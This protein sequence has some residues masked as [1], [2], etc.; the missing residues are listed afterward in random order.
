M[1]LT[2]RFLFWLSAIVLAATYL[3]TE[4]FLLARHELRAN[5]TR[6]EFT[7]QYD[8]VVLVIID[9]L[10]FDFVYFNTSLKSNE[11]NFYHNQ[12]G[13][14]HDLIQKAPDKARLFKFLADP[15]T[16][17]MQRLKGL[18]TGGLPTFIDV[19]DNFA[20]SAITEDNIVAQLTRHGRKVVMMGDDT[21]VSLFPKEFEQSFP[22]PS[23]NVKD[24]HT[25]DNGVL[26]HLLP[27]I[28][29][30]DEEHSTKWDLLIAHFLGVDHVGHRYGPSHQWMTNKLRQMNAVIGH[31]VCAIDSNCSVDLQAIPSYEGVQA[32]LPNASHDQA[33]TLLVVMGDHG[34]TQQGEHGG[35]TNDEVGAGMFVYSSHPIFSQHLPVPSRQASLFLLLD[36]SLTFYVGIQP[37]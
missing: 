26:T 35:A 18:T 2:L 15:P 3:F 20:S 12:L 1:G 17:T 32:A 34:M 29:R 9:A 36:F 19:K 4:G 7:Q 31:V 37:C 25:V 30:S 5:N 13:V 16:V 8:R 22:F 27:S 10:R 6:V 28:L 11:T 23:F 33:R 24:L 21:W 14:V